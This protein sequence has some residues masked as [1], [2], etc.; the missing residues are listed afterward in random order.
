MVPS[1]YLHTLLTALSWQ[2]L[3]FALKRA[4]WCVA[5]EMSGLEVCCKYPSMPVNVLYF[6][7]CFRSGPSSSRD[8][9]GPTTGVG[10]EFVILVSIFAASRILWIRNGCVSSKPVPSDNQ[11][12]STPR[13]LSTVPSSVKTKF[14]GPWVKVAIKLSIEVTFRLRIMQSST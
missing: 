13:Y 8:S 4:H 11:L 7:S 5:I 3:G 12:I 1:K 6:Q 9:N 2:S 10:L 14:S